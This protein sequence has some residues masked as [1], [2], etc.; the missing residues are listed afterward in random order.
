MTGLLENSAVPTCYAHADMW[1]LVRGAIALLM[2]KFNQVVG[3][4]P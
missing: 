1:K 3:R 4:S 2:W